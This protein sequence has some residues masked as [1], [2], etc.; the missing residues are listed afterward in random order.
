MAYSFDDASADRHTTQYFEMFCNRGIYH[1]GWTAVTRQHPCGH[2]DAGVRRRRLG[3]CTARTTGRGIRPRSRAAREA[4]RAQALFL[5]E[6]RKYNVL[7]LDDRRFER[8]NPDLAGRPQVVRGTSQLLYGS[9]GRLSE[10][11]IVAPAEPLARDHGRGLDPQG[12][13]TAS[14]SA[15]AARSAAS[16][17]TPRT[18]AGLPLQPLRPQQFKVY[19]DEPIPAGEHQVRMEFAYDGGGLGKEETVT[20][21]V[22]GEEVGQGRGRRSRRSSRPTRRPDVGSDGQRRRSATTTDRGTA[23]SRGRFAGCSSTSTRRQRTRTT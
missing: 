17:S 19:G 2:R 18:E 1:D 15:R 23:R 16:C 12:A 5:T 6:A 21:Y 22:D 14:S 20:L 11:S 7:P 3:P 13:P 10:N 8:F 4:R 9:M